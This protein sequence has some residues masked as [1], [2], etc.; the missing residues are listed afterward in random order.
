MAVVLCAGADP[1]LLKSTQ[2]ILEQA[3]H[4]TISATNRLAVI[5]ACQRV[6]FDVA[7]IGQLLSPIHK[8]SI[9]SLI[10]R[11]CPSARILELYQSN[12]HKAIDDADSWL[13]V[14]ADVPQELVEQVREL[15]K[16]KRQQMSA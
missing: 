1:T 2:L 14:L 9:G 13:E 6:I 7:V 15:A 5:S 8:R 11:Y 12:Q 3:D 10:R 4:S 16:R